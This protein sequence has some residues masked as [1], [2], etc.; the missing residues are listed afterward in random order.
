MCCSDAGFMGWE[1]EST[2]GQCVECEE[3]VDVD[4]D[5]TSSNNCSYSPTVC[6][7]CGWQPCDRSC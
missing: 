1:D 7:L 3:P 4:G 6:D 5:S 2:V